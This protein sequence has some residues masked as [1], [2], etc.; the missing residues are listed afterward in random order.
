MQDLRKQKSS[1]IEHTCRFVTLDRLCER[2]I[3]ELAACGKKLWLL[4]L[5]MMMR[6]MMMR[7]QSSGIGQK[8]QTAA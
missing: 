1:K 8:M 4:L 3:R 5:M 6:V 2:G 7:W